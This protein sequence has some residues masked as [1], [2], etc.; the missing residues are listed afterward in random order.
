MT[1]MKSIKL[2]LTV[3][4]I[5]IVTGTLAADN[6]LNTWLRVSAEVAELAIIEDIE[7]DNTFIQSYKNHTGRWVRL[8]ARTSFKS[9]EK[10]YGAKPALFKSLNNLGK[11]YSR[12]PDTEYYFV[13]FS[14]KYLKGLL[15]NGMKRQKIRVPRGEFIWPIQGSR[16]TSRIGTRWGRQHTGIDIAAGTGT[17]VIAARDGVVTSSGRYGAFG[18]TVEIDHQ[19]SYESRYAHLSVALVKEGDKIRKG[20]VIALSGNTGRSTGPHLHFEVRSMGIVLNPQMF[21]PEYEEY[22]EAAQAFHENLK[23]D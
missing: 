11:K 20:Q 13:P 8:S 19:N 22:L 14:E 9:L 7:V 18:I 1:K 2:F 16:I 21:L 4:L 17:L 10:K 6:S 5:F 23:A 12:V 15:A 3:S